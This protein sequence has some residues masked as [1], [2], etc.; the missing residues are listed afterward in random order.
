[1][2]QLIKNVG[3]LY[4]DSFRGLSK[5]IWLLSAVTFI[6]R[7]GSMVFLFLTVYMT[8]KLNFSLVEAGYVMSCAGVGSL[9]GAYMGG[10]LSDK[11][12]YYRVMFWS[13]FLVGCMFFLLMNIKTFVPLCIFMFIANLIGDAFRPA[14]FVAIGAYSTDENRTRSISLVRLFINLGLSA[15][16]AIGGIIAAYYGYK[17]LFVVDGITCIVAAFLFVIMLENIE[18][19]DDEVNQDKLDDQVEK[20]HFFLSPFQDVQYLFFLSCVFLTGVAFMQLIYTLPVFL[21]QDFLYNEDQIGYLL[22]LNCIVIVVLEMPIIYLFE[23]KYNNLNLAAIGA[24]LVGLSFFV[25]NPSFQIAGIAI[26]SMVI[27]SLGEIFNFPFANDYALQKTNTQNR[28][29]Y[30]GLYTMTFAAATIIAPTLGLFLAQTY[31]FTILWNCTA[32][33]C[34]IAGLGFFMLRTYK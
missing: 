19:K 31:G 26:I 18:P 28:G 2:I 27:I 34:C 16:P 17:W 15:G 12:G 4:V 6:N 9:A 7:S 14:N 29:K 25:F 5:N 1:M 11:F 20:K 13:L 3:N 22:A 23:N 32:I 10:I 33:L 21:K 30:M 24:I 8:S